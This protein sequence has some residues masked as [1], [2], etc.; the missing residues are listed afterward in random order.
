V[1]QNAWIALKGGPPGIRA[2][3]GL[4]APRAGLVRRWQVSPH[5]FSSGMEFRRTVIYAT[6]LKIGQDLI[7]PGSASEIGKP[8]RWHVNF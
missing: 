8:K 7:L 1:S 5:R 3:S 6:V 4:G 2:T